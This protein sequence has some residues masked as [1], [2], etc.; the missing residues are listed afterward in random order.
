MFSDHSQQSPAQQVQQSLLC[1]HRNRGC[2]LCLS[3]AQTDVSRTRDFS[4]QGWVPGSYGTNKAKNCFVQA[5][6]QTRQQR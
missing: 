3:E 4:G 1:V 6:I 2:R 5:G